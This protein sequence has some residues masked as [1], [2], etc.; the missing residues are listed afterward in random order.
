ML[1]I[2]DAR[3][4]KSKTL[5]TG[6]RRDQPSRP[7]PPLVKT[8]NNRRGLSYKWRYKKNGIMIV[9]CAQFGRLG[10]RGKQKRTAITRQDY[11]S[12][13][14]Q[15]HKGHQHA[16]RAHGNA[17]PARETTTRDSDQYEETLWSWLPSPFVGHLPSTVVVV[18]I[19]Y[20]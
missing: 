10:Y 6:G 9:N 1:S 16:I 20:L 5:S 14:L 7:R 8:I 18:S 15:P 17:T 13:T 11:N 4:K 3:A 2:L 12:S 19:A